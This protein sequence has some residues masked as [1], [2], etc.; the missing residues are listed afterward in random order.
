MTSHHAET[1]VAYITLGGAGSGKSTV[2]RRISSITGAAYLDKDTISGPFVE[3]A[4]GV[5]GHEATDRESNDTY[6]SRLMPL[7][8][9]T[10][11][12][13]AGRNLDLGHP[14]VLDA[15]FVAYLSDPDYLQRAIDAAA[16]PE[17]HIVVVHVTAS[18]DAVKQRLID[19]GLARDHVKLGEWENYWS[20]FGSLRCQWS[21]GQHHLFVNDDAQ[22]LLGIEHLVRRTTRTLP[23]AVTGWKGPAEGARSA[24]NGGQKEG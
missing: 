2:A 6:V 9:D 18:A 13:V 17:T 16:W 23:G 7:E 15:P 3:L 4:L 19:R 12:A 20:Q 1:P 8:Y 24:R 21:I 22:S 11:F 14:V 10:L 5:L